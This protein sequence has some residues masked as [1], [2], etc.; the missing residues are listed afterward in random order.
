MLSF[1]I[2]NYHKKSIFFMLWVK[3]WNVDRTYFFFFITKNTFF[4][5][6]LFWWITYPFQIT[7]ISIKCL[8]F[9]IFCKFFPISSWFN[10]TVSTNWKHLLSLLSFYPIQRI[11]IW[12]TM[13]WITWWHL[14]YNKWTQ[15][16]DKITDVEKRDWKISSITSSGLSLIMISMLS[17]FEC[18]TR[19]SSVSLEDIQLIAIV[20]LIFHVTD[21]VRSIYDI[22]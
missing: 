9:D 7:Y 8:S 22:F 1:S 3:F 14:Y 19:F 18:I 6:I 20:I 21:V 15:I 2:W 10:A 11:Y 5:I 13:I 17:I 16:K 12:S 4:L